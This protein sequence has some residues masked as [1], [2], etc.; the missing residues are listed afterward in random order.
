MTSLS[1]QQLLQKAQQGQG[2]AQFELATRLAG[3]AQP[4]YSSAMHWMKQAAEGGVM[5]ADS[6]TQSR[7][8]AQVATWYEQGLGEPKDPVKARSWWQQSAGLGN[9]QASWRLAQLCQ[10]NNGGKL[11]AECVDS[12]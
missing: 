1:D 11:V 7:A 9:A 5:A 3:K 2:R 8:A 12:L 4:D 6:T 10:H